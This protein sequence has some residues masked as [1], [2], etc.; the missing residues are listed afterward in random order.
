VRSEKSSKNEEN[1]YN[2]S[3]GGRRLKP[4]GALNSAR[5]RGDIKSK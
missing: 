5:I 3:L 4:I 2:L 1:E